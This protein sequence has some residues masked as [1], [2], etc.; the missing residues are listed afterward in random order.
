MLLEQITINDW[1]CF[2]GKQRIDFASSSKQNVTLIHA[3][4]GVGKTSLLNALLWC[5]YK[6]TTPRFEKP[7]DILNHQA[8]REGRRIASIAIEFSHEDILYEA[9]RVFRSDSSSASDKPVVSQISIDGQRQP[10]R[11][12]PNVFL[13]SVLPVDMAGHFLFDGEHAEA[14]TVKTNGS[15]VSNAI[16]DILGC[17]FVTQSIQALEG[18]AASYRRKATTTN[19]LDKSS[20][21]SKNIIKYEKY[22]SQKTQL[23]KDLNLEIDG[24]EAERNGIESQL[25]SVAAIKQTQTIKLN[26]EDT[27]R[28]EKRY[29]KR[30]I[31][32][33]QLWLSKNGQTVLGKKIALGAFSIVD[34]YSKQN[35]QKSLFNKE[36][37]IQIL[38]VGKCVCGTPVNTNDELEHH[39][40][41]QLETAESLELQKRITKVTSLI[42]RLKVVNIFDKISDY[43]SSCQAQ[44][45]H[46]DAITRAEISYT[47]ITQAL[48]AHD[49]GKISNLQ[50]KSTHI[51][52]EISGKQRTKG[53]VSQQLNQAEKKLRSFNSSLDEIN[54]NSSDGMNFMKNQFLAD[55]VKTS[56]EGKLEEEIE[57]ARRVINGYVREIIEKTARKNF[58][59][60]IDKNFSV[61]LLDEYGTDM[62]KSEGEN[63]LLGLAF[64]GA[65]AKFAKLRK[66]AKSKILLPGTEAPLVLDAPFGKLDPIYKHATAEF[67]PKMSSQVIVMVNQEQGSP[68]VL[69]LLRDRVG[70]QYALV[71]HNRSPQ[72]NKASETL[73]V[74]GKNIKITRY[75]STFDGT[76]IELV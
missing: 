65:L 36:V 10:M 69:D 59:V 32:E 52:R 33:Q 35:S 39:L 60:I 49:L 62:A 64:T 57:N 75:E 53:E 37:I 46:F 44:A 58:D 26:T 1:R 66:N 23:I 51:Y 63:Q 70:Y 22:I 15:T 48:A 25:S 40:R 71:R 21:L 45:D 72:N 12:D 6:K 43:E 4:N 67:L 19:A 41:G 74:N 76:A 20:E 8:R 5:F 73:I 31:V 34:E 3:E 2:Y 9:M 7:S 28:N 42:Q 68:K 55:A 13:N 24:L 50:S 18:I 17:T 54:R 16:K 61:K 30:A 29:E 14:L 27:I 47:E 11:A 38:E 56:L